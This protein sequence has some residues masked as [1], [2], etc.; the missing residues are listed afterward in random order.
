MP[1]IW[2]MDSNGRKLMKRG[3]GGE[4]D[5]VRETERRDIGIV[6]GRG[7][8][9]LSE[10]VRKAINPQLFSSLLLPPSC[11]LRYSSLLQGSHYETLKGHDY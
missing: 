3:E 10:Q 9:F 11:S 4:D 2:L 8:G 1:L 7:G 6:R 5:V